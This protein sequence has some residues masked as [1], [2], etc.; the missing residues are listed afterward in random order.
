M[1]KKAGPGPGHNSGSIAADRL[2]SFVQR[3]ERLQGDIDG[4]NQDKSDVFKEAKG[5]GFDT[6]VMRRVIRRLG[7]LEKDKAAVEEM[8]ALEALYL[9]AVGEG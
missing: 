2:R 8:D 5:A 7:A 4:L 9:D 3:I 1:V 6:K